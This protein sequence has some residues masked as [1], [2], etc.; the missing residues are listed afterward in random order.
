[1]ARC[2]RR[3]DP[4]SPATAPPKC[5]SRLGRVAL[6]PMAGEAAVP[7]DLKLKLPKP[8]KKALL[9]AHGEVLARE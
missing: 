4:R 9:N 6:L 1:M 7:V 8:G 5:F 3:G 2:G